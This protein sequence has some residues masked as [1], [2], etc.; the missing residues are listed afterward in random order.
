MPQTI[1]I[2]IRIYP[3]DQAILVEMGNTYIQTV[4]KL[5]EQAEMSGMF[6][7]LT[8]KNLSV[9]LP[10]AVKNQIIRDA[11]SIFKKVN[12][13]KKRP[14]LKK[15]VYHINNQNYTIGENSVS[16][17][18]F[19]DG[20]VQRLVVPAHIPDQERTL[21][22]D[23]KNGLLRVVQKSEKW[24]V[25]VAIE[26]PTMQTTGDVVM[27]VDL[28]LK[29]PAVSVTSNGKT[30]FYG[31]GRKNKF[32]RRKYLSHRRKLGKLKKLSAIRKM[33]DKESRYMRDQNH[34]ISREIVNMA[35][36]QNVSIIK[37]EKLTNLRKT[38]RQS[39]KNAKN[40]HNWSFFQL[41]MFITYKAAI[42][43]IKVGQVNP[44]FTSQTCPICGQLNK[45]KDR[46]YQCTCGYQAHR[47]RV[48]AINIMYQPVIDGNSLSA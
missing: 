41:Q 48:G 11:K 39:R 6:P 24:F 17:P 47:D 23:S 26:R 21:L 46:T 30:K 45:A 34:K 37:L 9:N 8:S 4:N 25:Q 10:S 14:I 42:A 22:S 31:N 19:M 12:K 33:C 5:T 40:L 20:K 2:Q 27:G 28:G 36:K 1:T 7:K 29:V 32:I 18:V 3:H 16:F 15:P 44:A 13:L 35:I 43:G 38:T